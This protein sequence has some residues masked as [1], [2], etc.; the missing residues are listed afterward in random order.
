MQRFRSVRS[1][2]D[3]LKGN[4]DPAI[5]VAAATFLGQF[6]DRASYMALLDALDIRIRPLEIPL[7]AANALRERPDAKMRIEIARKKKET[8]K[9]LTERLQE[10]LVDFQ[11]REILE[12]L[13]DFRDNRSYTASIAD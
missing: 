1:A 2:I 9:R 7:A 10:E 12:K 6:K 13:G 8:V 11:R 3:A 5:R 4:C